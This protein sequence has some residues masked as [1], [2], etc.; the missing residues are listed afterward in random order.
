M[1]FSNDGMVRHKAGG[2]RGGWEED[3]T[4]EVEDQESKAKQQSTYYTVCG[5]IGT[6]RSRLDVSSAGI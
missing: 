5:Y 1:S 3:R 4:P 2:S 6:R